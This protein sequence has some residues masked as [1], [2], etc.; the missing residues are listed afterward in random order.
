M[1]S[2]LITTVALILAMALPASAGASRTS[3]VTVGGGEE[4]IRVTIC[5]KPLAHNREQVCKF[6]QT[7]YGSW[8]ECI[9]RHRR[10][11]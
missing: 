9:V 2:R 1:R 5:T 3:C 7:E 11:R 4:E 6:V 10:R 8:S